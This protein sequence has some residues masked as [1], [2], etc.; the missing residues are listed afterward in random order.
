MGAMPIYQKQNHKPANTNNNAAYA[1]YIKLMNT[2]VVSAPGGNR[3]HKTIAVEA[4][5]SQTFDTSSP[6]LFDRGLFLCIVKG[7]ADTDNTP[8][9]KNDCIVDLHYR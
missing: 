5:K 2:S 8:V 7:L 6:I 3:V 9:L 1:I 4:G